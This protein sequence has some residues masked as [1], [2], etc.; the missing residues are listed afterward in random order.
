M[1]WYKHHNIEYY[2]DETIMKEAGLL[3]NLIIGEIMVLAPLLGYLGWT[4]MDISNKLQ[5][6]NNDT[7]ALKQ[8]AI[9]EAQQQ[10]VPEQIIQQVQNNINNQP[11]QEV[12]EQAPVQKE[13]TAFDRM[14]QKLIDNEGFVNKANPIGRRGEIDI[15]VGHAM[16]NP[17]NGRTRAT[18]TVV[19]RRIFSKL[20]GNTVN[21]DAVLNG[22]QELTDPQIEQL[23]KH[24]IDEHSNR[25]KRLFKNPN[26]FDSLPP[27]LQDAIL[28]GVYRGD[29]GTRAT[30]MTVKHMNANNWVA[31][32]KEY[33]D[34]KG[35]RSAKQRGL[36]GVRDRMEANQ[37][38]MF[39]YAKELGQ[40]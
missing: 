5:N 4:K 18:Q 28:D 37:K 3:N 15:G 8:E 26:H 30:P 10:N 21:F 9:E 33:L 14:R 19:S 1:N 13:P 23:L 11:Q 25:A 7:T 22:Q 29:I 36:G 34:H 27:Y 31:A 39:Q 40:I 17:N 35:Y 2:L 12:T 16:L 20:F 38:A 24:D 6:N 32:A